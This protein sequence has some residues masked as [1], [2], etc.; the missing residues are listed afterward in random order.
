[1]KEVTADGTTA[2]ITFANCLSAGADYTLTVDSS[3]GIAEDLVIKFKTDAG[4]KKYGKP[5]V[6]INGAS[7]DGDAVSVVA[8]DKVKVE[9]QIINTS[10]EDAEYFIAIAGYKGGTF[11][12]VDVDSNAITAEGDYAGT[13]KAELTVD[14]EFAG[15]DEIKAFLFDGT[16]YIRPLAEPVILQNR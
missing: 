7:Q 2:T 1:M 10:A 5:V 11:V 9:A 15:V 12:A 16:T 6:S 13:A 4:E 8:G 3:V 14:A